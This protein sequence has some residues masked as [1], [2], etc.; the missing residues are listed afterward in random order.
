MDKQQ[1]T[2][3]FHLIPSERNKPCTHA[4]RVSY[5]GVKRCIMC[6]TIIYETEEE[7]RRYG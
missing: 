5:N 6:G 1:P 2:Q 3:R 7:R 4:L